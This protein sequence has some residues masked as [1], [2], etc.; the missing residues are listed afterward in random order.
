MKI[1]HGP[2]ESAAT[3]AGFIGCAVRAAAVYTACRFP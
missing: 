2:V 3:L 1:P